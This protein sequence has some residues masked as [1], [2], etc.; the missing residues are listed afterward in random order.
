MSDYTIT[1]TEFGWVIGVGGKPVLLVADEE[2]ARQVVS[3]AEVLLRNG[4]SNH[5]ALSAILNVTVKSPSMQ[6]DAEHDPVM[7]RSIPK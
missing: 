2:L 5:S 7:A 3:D 4:S 6:P 1:P